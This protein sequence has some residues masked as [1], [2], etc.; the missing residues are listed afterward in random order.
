MME[1]VEAELEEEEEEPRLR[2]KTAEDLVEAALRIN[3]PDGQLLGVV[4]LCHKEA[5][6]EVRFDV[7]NDLLVLKCGEC[8][9]PCQLVRL[10]RN[11]PAS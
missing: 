1:A 2:V 9:R 11:L 3:L 4:P 5:A 10:G 8:Q 7:W 6:W